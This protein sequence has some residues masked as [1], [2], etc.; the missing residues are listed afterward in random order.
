M[1]DPDPTQAFY[2][3]WARLYDGFASAP[4]IRSWRSRAVDVLDLTPGDTVVEMGVGTGANLPVLRDAV[5]AEGRV[6]GVDITREMLDVARRRV[7]ASAWNN[8][9]LVRG[10]ATRPPVDGPVDAVLGSFVIGMVEHPADV[11]RTWAD[12]L[13]ADGRIAL[14]DAARSDRRLAAPINL[15]LR[16]FVG[17][18]APDKRDGAEPA[19]EILESRLERARDALAAVT[20]SP[21]ERRFAGGIVRLRWGRRHTDE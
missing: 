10:D 13:G 17:L 9:H 2:G 12:L 4:W 5:G 16:A 18:T 1:S 6:V 15:G 20:V 14:L 8:V 3:R 11:I 19:I 7:T 21:Q